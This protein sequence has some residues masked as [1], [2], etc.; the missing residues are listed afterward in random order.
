MLI[1]S[2][3]SD[4][5]VTFDMFDEAT[6]E[7]L[8]PL[9][10]SYSVYDDEGS[11]VDS[12]AV[13]GIVGDETEIKVTVTAVNNSIGA[14]ANGARTVVLNVTTASGSHEMNQTY[15]LERFA[16][17]A[18]PTES[19][20]TLPQAMM[21][22]RGVAQ[23]AVEIW[24]DVE[25]NERKAALREAWFRLSSI[26]FKPWRSDQVIPNDVPAELISWTTPLNE[27]TAES[28]SL[29]PEN[30]KTALKRAQLLEACVLLGGDAAW[31]R[32]QDGLISKTVGESSEMFVSNKASQNTVSPRAF[33]ELRAYVKRSITIGRG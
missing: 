18:V 16:F 9:S 19:G 11:V 2:P 17:L 28:W 1:H 24:A 20:M 32:R 26:P 33:R 23:S 30:F 13:S 4:V 10:A 22:S 5:S 27:L 12:G 15:V 3:D 8:A 6:G 14:N 7:T 21:L 25:D 29:L 31:D